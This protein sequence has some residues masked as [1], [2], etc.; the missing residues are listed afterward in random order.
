MHNYSLH[1]VTL[2]AIAAPAE[3]LQIAPVMGATSSKG[4]D[5]VNGE[6]IRHVGS[7]PPTRAALAVQPAMLS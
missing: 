7:H 1:S 5:V 2:T 4:S 6:V 3:H